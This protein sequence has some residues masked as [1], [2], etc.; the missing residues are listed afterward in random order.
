MTT[1][2]TNTIQKKDPS[3]RIENVMGEMRILIPAGGSPCFYC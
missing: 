2:T 3:M 1:T